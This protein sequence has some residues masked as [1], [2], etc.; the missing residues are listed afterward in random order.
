MA[1]A[2]IPV[3]INATAF[4]SA[5]YKQVLSGIKTAAAKMGRTIRVFTEDGFDRL[6][7][8]PWPRVM[9]ATGT[10]LPFLRR[11][12]AQ[13]EAEDR[14]VVL[15]G[16]DSDQFGGLVSCAT[17][18]R[19]TEMQQVLRYL[20]RCGRKRIALVGFDEHS[21]NDRYRYHAALSLQD[22]L[23]LSLTQE[24]AYR[25]TTE[26]ENSFRDFFAH[27]GQYD[28]AVCPNDVMA[29]SF[30]NFLRR[31]GVSL[32]G[33]M[34]IASFGGMELSRWAKPGITTT[35]MNDFQV[36]QQAMTVWNLIRENHA[37]G[38]VMK[39]SL[40]SYIIPRESTAFMPDE[41]AA[42]PAHPYESA[43]DFYSIPLVSALVRLD[44]CLTRRDALD[45]KILSHL[46]R[47][48]SYE[49]MGERLFISGS[50]LRYR[51]QKMYR[52]ADA[53]NRADFERMIHTHLGEGNPF[54]V[55]EEEKVP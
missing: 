50:A 18:S 39:I 15:A 8:R 3:V 43:D 41:A 20:M 55:P 14:R 6:D 33:E 16:T 26:P 30:S 37:S 23:G 21:I 5:Q 48:E 1:D 29:V 47:G 36:G 2:F 46:M 51:L 10:S 40:P 24:D 17:H 11:V 12:I 53:A 54:E 44:D 34:F 22:T 7:T 38:M 13:M 35:R 19:R 42:V 32:P 52:D 28:A 25:W 4:I 9:I 49:E 27:I 31:R 45:F